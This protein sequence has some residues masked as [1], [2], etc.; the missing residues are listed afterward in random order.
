MPFLERYREYCQSVTDAP[1]KFHEYIGLATVA[2]VM[3]N[4][5]RLGIGDGWIYPNLWIILVAASSRFRKSTCLKISQR[6]IERCSVRDIE[7]S[8]RASEEALI[9]QLNQRPYGI[10]YCD[11]LAS[12]AG[13][14]GRDFMRGGKGLWASVYDGRL[15][16]EFF[17]RGQHQG[18]ADL[19]VSFTAATTMEWLVDQLNE[20]DI[21]GGLLPRFL[22]VPAYSKETSMPLPPMGDQKEQAA[23]AAELDRISL[24]EG[25]MFLP[26]ESQRLYTQWF[27]RYDNAK[28]DGTRADP[29]IPRL[30]TCCLKIAMIL[31]V[32]HDGQRSIQPAII[33]Q[34][35]QYT[36]WAM[37][38]VGTLCQQEL[39]FSKHEEQV[40]RVRQLLQRE[41][42]WTRLR[43]L[44]RTCHLSKQDLD[45]VLATCRASEWI[46]EKRDVWVTDSDTNP[47]ER[48][49]VQQIRWLGMT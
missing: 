16:R 15:P 21:R 13:L 49:K 17:K 20:S 29:W 41:E 43:D 1:W 7:L 48:K 8:W 40:K 10:T 12:F 30:A 19:A 4:R 35:C 9:E 25:D 34:A 3:G 39:T 38:Q 47:D 37:Q 33:Q 45:K 31:Q 5:W 42:G 46:Q 6:M 11:E 22:V 24:T 26:R 2:A 14:M 28:L 18:R 23:L 32:D 44:Q 27:M 36:S